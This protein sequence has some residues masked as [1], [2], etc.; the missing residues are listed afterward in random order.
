MKDNMRIL[1]IAV[2]AVLVIEIVLFYLFTQ[3]FS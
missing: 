1:Y 2:V 3:H